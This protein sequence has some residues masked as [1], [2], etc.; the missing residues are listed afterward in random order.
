MEV[1]PNPLKGELIKYFGNLS[2]C[3][4]LVRRS[5]GRPYSAAQ[6]SSAINNTLKTQIGMEIRSKCREL[7]FNKEKEMKTHGDS[8]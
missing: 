3:R 7:I 4:A 2:T 6:F 5:D 8:V 1:K